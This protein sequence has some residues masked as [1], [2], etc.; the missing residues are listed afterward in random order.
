MRNCQIAN[1]P[2][3]LLNKLDSGLNSRLLWSGNQGLLILQLSEF[4]F[5]AAFNTFSLQ[6]AK[7]CTE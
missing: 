3:Y 5:R 7:L 1:I 6:H 2:S 4:T